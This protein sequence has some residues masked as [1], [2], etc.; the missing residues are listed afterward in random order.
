MEES[1]KKSQLELL[2]LTRSF[3]DQP[4]LTFLLTMNPLTFKRST[5]AINNF[6][7]LALRTFRLINSAIIT[8]SENI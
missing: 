4:L 8:V 7:Y 1:I 6:S 3:T 2:K 5:Q